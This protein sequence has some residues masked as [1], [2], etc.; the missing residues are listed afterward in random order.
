MHQLRGEVVSTPPL[1]RH[2]GHTCAA[3]CWGEDVSRRA[4]VGRLRRQTRLFAGRFSRRRPPTRL[5]LLTYEIVARG[6]LDLLLAPLLMIPGLS[7]WLR[8]WLQRRMACAFLGFEDDAGTRVG[9]MLHPTRWNGQEMRPRAAFALLRGLGCGAPDY[10][11]LAAHW[12]ARA[13]WNERDAFTRRTADH[14]WHDFSRAAVAF[15]PAP[16]DA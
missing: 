15:R 4:L 14:D 12:F 10:Y 16:R 3:C 11:C 8:P 1:C 7:D 9:C 6:F 2:D 5:R 13:S